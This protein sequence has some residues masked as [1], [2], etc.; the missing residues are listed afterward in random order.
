MT[1]RVSST[2]V[3]LPVSNKRPLLISV[4]NYFSRTLRCPSVAIGVQPVLVKK[5]FIF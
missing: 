4:T 2:V 5:R 1:F 3:S